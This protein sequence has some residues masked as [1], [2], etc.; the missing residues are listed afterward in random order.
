MVSAPGGVV[1]PPRRVRATLGEQ[2]GA[3][4]DCEKTDR[5]VDEEDPLPAKAVD[6]GTPDQPG[7]RRPEAAERSPDSE[8]LVALGALGEQGR[9]DRERGRGHDRGTDPL[10]GAGADQRLVRPGEPAEKRSEREESEAD[11]EH[12]PP[13][14]QV[15]GSPSEQEQPGEGEGIGAHYPLQPLRRE[16]EI[17]LDRGESD[18]HDRGVEND[19]EEGAA[20]EGER[21]PA[22]GI[23]SGR[24]ARDRRRR[25]HN[26][27][28]KSYSAVD[29]RSGVA[30][31]LI[32]PRQ[33][34]SRD[35]DEDEWAR[36]DAAQVSYR[37]P[38]DRDHRAA[39]EAPA[40]PRPALELGHSLLDDHD[41][42]GRGVRKVELAPG[43]DS[44]HAPGKARG[45]RIAKERIASAL[46]C[47]HPR[48]LGS[49]KAAKSSGYLK[50]CMSAIRP[51][52]I[53]TTL[54]A[55]GSASA[56]SPR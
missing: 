6:E 39:P 47:G 43:C 7:G 1:A 33:R 56:P 12:P 30:Q 24:D 52:S 18:G 22:A 28:P 42:V 11:H 35:G 17:L 5:D 4:R 45:E 20:E 53:V 49:P 36:A 10:E 26:Q 55:N 51:D 2:N 46:F 16:G 38:C 27:P 34:R 54:I 25:F 29:V 48:V 23:E 37:E 50:K 8:R 3:E 19:H 31:K 14:E 9:D 15:R 44:Q 40:H 13:P 21:P 41:R 32:D